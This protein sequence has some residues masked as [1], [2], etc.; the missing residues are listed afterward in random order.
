MI[1]NNIERTINA[2]LNDE[3]FQSFFQ[4]L[5]QRTFE[6]RESL[7]HAGQYCHH[8]FFINK[9]I[10]YSFWEDE[11]A[12]HHTIQFAFEGYWIADLSS[13]FSGHPAIFNIESLEPT[14]VWQLSRNN[15]ERACHDIA[16][17]ERFF[18]I[19]IQRAYVNMQ[20]RLAKTF[21][22]SADERYL[23][24]LKQH[25]DILQRV[26]QYLVA[27]YLGIKPQSLSRLRARILKKNKS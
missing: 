16:Q 6:R 1:R 11:K 14:I 20:H 7:I 10:A 8:I 15:F 13:F 21:S 18:R 22:D 23:T 24:L 17:F 5:E 9:G 25:P 27:S 12:E 19:L 3:A 2:R 26:P 4:L